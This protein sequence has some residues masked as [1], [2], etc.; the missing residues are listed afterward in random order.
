MI[1]VHESSLWCFRIERKEVSADGRK[2]VGD[3][4][5]IV[6]CTLLRSWLSESSFD[7]FLHVP[8]TDVDRRG[9]PDLSNSRD[10]GEVLVDV[11]DSRLDVLSA[12]DDVKE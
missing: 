6:K 5:R 9:R 1:G 4:F 3:F 11:N 2:E 12:P 8:E 7:R 10:L